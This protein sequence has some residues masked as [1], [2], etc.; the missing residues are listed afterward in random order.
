MAHSLEERIR[1]L[2]YRKWQAAGCLP[3]ADS[4]HWLAAEQEVL[5]QQ[6]AFTRFRYVARRWIGGKTGSAC[7]NFAIVVISGGAVAWWVYRCTDWAETALGIF[8]LGAFVSFAAL[9]LNLLPKD[10]VEALQ[11]E[12]VGPILGSYYV[13]AAAPALLLLLFLVS[14]FAGSVEIEGGKGS[15]DMRVWA[16]SPDTDPKA[17]DSAPLSANGR[18]RFPC[19]TTW[20]GRDYRI[21]VT[22][23]PEKKVL[24]RSW[25]TALG[26]QRFLAPTDFLRPVILIGAESSLVHIPS[27]K[28]PVTLHVSVTRSVGGK[29]ETK[30]YHADYDGR[31][32]WIGCQEGDLDVPK[33]LKDH[34]LWAI[35]LST[36]ETANRLLP[37]V[38]LK[39]LPEEIEPGDL[40]TVTLTKPDHK[41]CEPQPLTIRRPTS[42][43]DIIQ[44]ITLLYV[45]E[46]EGPNQ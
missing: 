12:V 13:V 17:A 23:L 21:K 39:G 4:A 27:E 1:S 34:K 40:V 7:I 15:G 45:H 28:N 9:V 6:T 8:T 37:P 30:D 19:W 22:G 33:Q 24:V 35:A 5:A 44:V 38:T 10:Q 26:P 43:E 29:K 31:A 3:G 41:I 2:A 11:K 32:V 46:Q 18:V 36:A 42:T 14:S 20:C 16:Y 25:V